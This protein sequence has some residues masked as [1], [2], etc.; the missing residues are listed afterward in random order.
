MWAQDKSTP[1]TC[2][3][4]SSSLGDMA[5]GVTQIQEGC[6]KKVAP[7]DGYTGVSEVTTWCQT[8]PSGRKTSYVQLTI[9]VTALHPFSLEFHDCQGY[10]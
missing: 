10:N 2:S 9:P 4:H 8:L 1:D 7:S 5:E 3:E 6:P